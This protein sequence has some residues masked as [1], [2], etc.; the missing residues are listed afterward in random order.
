MYECRKYLKG[1]TLGHNVCLSVYWNMGVG[2]KYKRKLYI[3]GK[4]DTYM[5]M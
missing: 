4:L 3:Y 1:L 2:T 5:Y